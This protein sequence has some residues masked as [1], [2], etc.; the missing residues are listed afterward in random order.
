MSRRGRRNKIRGEII[1]IAIMVLTVV[2]S[3]IGYQEFKAQIAA[4]TTPTNTTELPPLNIT[5]TPT[6]TP[7]TN[8]TATN[9]TAVATTTTEAQAAENTTTTQAG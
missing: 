7:A 2:V 1:L 6:T 3:V 8:T 4:T 5:T 9:T